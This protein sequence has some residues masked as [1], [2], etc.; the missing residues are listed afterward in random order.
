VVRH[1]HRIIIAGRLGEI[2]HQA[3]TDLTIEPYETDTALSASSIW[4]RAMTHGTA[5]CRLGS[6]WWH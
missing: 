6:N 4:P 3:F 2:G 5:L 1:R